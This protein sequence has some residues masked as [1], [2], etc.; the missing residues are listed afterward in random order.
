MMLPDGARSGGL[1][2]VPA[3]R[4]RGRMK[5]FLL[6]PL[7]AGLGAGLLPPSVH[8]SPLEVGLGTA[9]RQVAS[10]EVVTLSGTA[11]GG[12]GTKTYEWTQR[13]GPAVTL[14]DANR[15]SASFTAP[16][17]T[18]AT[19]LSFLLAVTD[20]D[21]ASGS[22]SV[23][24]RVWP[25]ASPVALSATAGSNQAAVGGE[26]VTL[27]GSATGGSGTKRYAWTQTG[28]SPTVTINNASQASASFTAPPV[29]ARTTLTFTLTVTAGSETATD[30]VSV[31]VRP[32]PLGAAAGSNQ[33]A[34]SGE[35]VTLSGSA[36]GGSGTKRYAWTQTGGS[37]TV[38][39]SNAS[40]ASA[41]FTAPSV[42]A[43]TEL[44]FT[45]TVT[46]GSETATDAVTVT[47]RPPS[48]GAA[49]GPDQAVAGGE[50]V[51]LSGSATNSSG[52]TSYAWTQTGGSPTV[53]LSNANR[54]SASFTAPSVTAATG[55]EFTLTVTDDSDSATDTVTVTVAAPLSAAAGSDQAAAG[56][57]TVTLSGSATGGSETKSYAWTQTGGSP[58]VTLSNANQ[59]SASFTAPT[60]TAATRLEFTLTVTAGSETATDAVSVMVAA[61]PPRVTDLSLASR[62]R[63]GDTYKQGETIRVQVWL[64]GLAVVTGSPRL[65]LGV[66]TQ[67]RTMSYVGLD[68][69]R[70]LE[71]E[72]T[73]QAADADADGVS[74]GSTALSLPPGAT[75]AGVDGGTVGV[76]LSGHA[77]ANAP[78]HKVDGGQ[79]SA[80]PIPDLNACPAE[81]QD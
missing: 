16:T 79:S 46:A 67:M 36:T 44:E 66:G 37:P 25:P 63:A 8:A 26:T 18:A 29:T 48:L 71:F 42:T 54:A 47:V 38:T 60:V 70:V 59:A 23:W 31:T 1:P 20:E 57:E 62:P 5:R 43:A 74:I 64:S 19:W 68:R 55:L 53:A 12:R 76:S 56:G 73:V 27:S 77:I 34:A 65:A 39:L 41:R 78:G 75:L 49:A 21:G 35:T 7:L 14:N 24:I 58:T 3:G 32:P 11:T 81:G 15:A 2:G 4:R 6:L 22:A 17:V 28:G 30:T 40:Q 72:Y 61:E 45:L 10:G 52:T 69:A 80:S 50:T 13:Y 9:V 33:A 51:T